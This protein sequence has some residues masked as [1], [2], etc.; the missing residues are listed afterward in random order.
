LATVVASDKA[1]PRR[2]SS[3]ASSWA[4][5]ASVA[6]R[7][8]PNRSISQLTLRAAEYWLF[9]GLTVAGSGVMPLSLLWARLPPKLTP[10]CGKSWARVV[11]N[12]PA[13]SSTRAAA[14]FISRL[15]A[16]ASATSA[17]STG[18]SSCVHQARLASSSGFSLAGKALPLRQAAG[19]SSVGRA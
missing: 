3:V 2:A 12:S 7:R 1:T 16:S 18:S 19:V 14:I 10:S 5:L 13:A 8:R 17:S 9:I 15:L 11:P 4:W 6:R